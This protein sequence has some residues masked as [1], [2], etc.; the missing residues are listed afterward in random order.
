[1]R[2]MCPNTQSASERARDI[3]FTSHLTRISRPKN[4]IAWWRCAVEA[5][6]WHTSGCVRLCV[7]PSDWTTCRKSLRN[8]IWVR[9]LLVLLWMFIQVSQSDPGHPSC[10]RRQHRRRSYRIVRI[11]N[12]ASAFMQIP[13]LSGCVCACVLSSNAR[14]TCARCRIAH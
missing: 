7:H 3:T 11:R 6:R 14:I 13:N 4:S 9:L 2:L 8:Q 12:S 5:A 1:M 10:M